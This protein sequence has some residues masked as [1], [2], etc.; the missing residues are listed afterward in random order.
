M[1]WSAWILENSNALWMILV[2]I[3][4]ISTKLP[5]VTHNTMLEAILG[6]ALKGAEKETQNAPV[7]TDKK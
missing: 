5:F 7:V 6:A 1:T 3:L 2:G 4:L